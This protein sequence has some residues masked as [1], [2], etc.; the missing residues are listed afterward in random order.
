MCAICDGADSLPEGEMPCAEQLTRFGKSLQQ[1]MGEGA[2]SIMLLQ[3]VGILRIPTTADA[4]DAWSSMLLGVQH[5]RAQDVREQRRQHHRDK[6][7]AA[8][9]TLFGV[10]LGWG[11]SQLQTV[12]F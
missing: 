1:V 12:F 11:I 4:R 9:L 5:G 3:S 6:F 10:V 8:G 7:F 2:A